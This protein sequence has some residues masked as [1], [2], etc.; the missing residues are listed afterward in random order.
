MK[1]TWP[2]NRRAD[3]EETVRHADVQQQIEDAQAK[4][5]Q[6]IRDDDR[7]ESLVRRTDRV[8]GENN[9]AVTVRRALGVR[10]S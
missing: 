9:F 3:R 10:P 1:W 4:L 8:I 2:W 7:V 6:V 5:E